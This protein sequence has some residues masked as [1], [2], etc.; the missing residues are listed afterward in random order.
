MKIG[1]IF[2]KMKWKD[3]DSTMN[4]QGCPYLFSGEWGKESRLQ[5]CKHTYYDV[6]YRYTHNRE[7]AYQA[8]S[9]YKQ[10]SIQEQAF[11]LH[12]YKQSNSAQHMM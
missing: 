6:S 8:G 9:V 12:I 4:S 5:I 1:Q 3:K 2:K 7:F 11:P 10:T